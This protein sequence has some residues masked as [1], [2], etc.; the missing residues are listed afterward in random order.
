MTLPLLIVATLAL[1]AAVEAKGLRSPA[2]EI[3]FHE[4][5][6]SRPVDD[7]TSLSTWSS[8]GWKGAKASVLPLKPG[9]AESSLLLETTVDTRGA[10]R[11]VF[12]RSLG[13]PRDWSGY[14]GIRFKMRA[15]SSD[16]NAAIVLR[17]I[18]NDEV[19]MKLTFP[20]MLSGGER[21]VVAPFPAEK[22]GALKN[23]SLLHF[24]LDNR[25]YAE[26]TAIRLRL[27]DFELVNLKE[28]LAPLPENEA[29]VELF[30]GDADSVA[31][32]KHGAELPKCRAVV[33]TGA[34]CVL[35]PADVLACVATDLFTDKKITFDQ[36]LGRAVKVAARAEFEIKLPQ[37]PP[38]YYWVTCDLKRAGKSLVNGRVGFA[39]FY[40]RAENENMTHTILSL[41]TGMGLYIIDPAGAYGSGSIAFMHT[42]DPRDADHYIDFIRA[43]QYWSP[44]GASTSKDTEVLEAGVT[45]TVFAAEAFRAAGEL[46]RAR[47]AE[48]L[49]KSNIDYMIDHVQNP[50]GS[51][52][53]DVNVYLAR[54]P[55]AYQDTMT[56]SR[57]PDTNQVGEWLRSLAR[58]MIYF[59]NVPGEQDYVTKLYKAGLISAD[60]IVRVGTDQI[61]KHKNVIRHFKLIDG[62]YPGG[63]R[64]LYEQEGRQCD[65]YLP[66]AMAGLSYFAYVRQLLAMHAVHGSPDPAP[67]TPAMRGSHD[68]AYTP[69]PQ[70]WLD[71]MRDTTAWA[72]DKMAPDTGWFDT[73][74]GYEVEGGCHAFLGNMYLA[75]ATQGYY[76]LCAARKDLD[77]AKLAAE[78]TRRALYFVTDHDRFTSRSKG[79]FEFWVG[80]YL[81]WQFTEYLG[82]IAPDPKFSAYLQLLHDGW[83]ERRNWQDFTQRTG[84]SPLFR[85]NELSNI[86][87]SILAYPALRFMEETGK[88]FRYPVA[89]L[90]DLGL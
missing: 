5:I 50:D 77:G 41:R 31:L 15:Y 59:M 66:R 48:K 11:C 25:G 72:M 49:L 83:A 30:I 29:G 22:R 71:A 13:S 8:S 63:R 14:E 17:L 23:V 44:E 64:E 89:G 1:C 75:E 69:V 37:V 45:G 9:S 47:F 60:Y 57:A 58:A 55:G 18:I 84:Q 40:Q 79:P 27:W 43:Y 61:G 54:N 56:D 67:S 74:C 16:P 20:A 35:T 36:P 32:V 34:D 88:P 73:Q 82:S 81:Y 39:D 21:T 33:H 28:G 7:F 19:Q 78:A 85:A 86:H 42:Y 76:L 2:W 65:V 12:E 80:P 90:R 87:Q 38:G 70:D 3:P 51:T 24:F 68:P 53:W 26:D 4:V 6:G 62:K 46:D 52:K 10:R